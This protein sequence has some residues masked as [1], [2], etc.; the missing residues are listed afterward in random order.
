MGVDFL[1]KT[2]LAHAKAW[3]TEFQ[4]S[5]EDLFAPTC[6]SLRRSFLASVSDE[7]ALREGDPVTV[8]LVNDQV[9]VLK[10]IYPIARIEKPS[11]DLVEHLAACYGVLPGYIDDTNEFARTVSVFVGEKK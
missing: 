2:K 7:A 4:R 8:R 11:L 10:E 1:R 5:S 3:S 9:L 6:D